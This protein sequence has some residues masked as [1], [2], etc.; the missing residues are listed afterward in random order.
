MMIPELRARNHWYPDT[1]PADLT[2]GQWEDICIAFDHRCAYCGRAEKQLTRDHRVPLIRGGRHTASNIVPACHRCNKSK[3]S[4]TE[5]EFRSVLVRTGKLAVFQ[6]TPSSVH[7]VLNL[8]EWCGLSQDEMLVSEA[9]QVLGL[10]YPTVNGWINK[11]IIESHLVKGYRVLWRADVEAFKA[12]PRRAGR[13][14]K[15][16]GASDA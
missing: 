6:S 16:E 4:K 11:K 7:R 2:T 3:G 5:E 14:R 1:G 10:T 8:R 15:S 12:I 9:A 13:P